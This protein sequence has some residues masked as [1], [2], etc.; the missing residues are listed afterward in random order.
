MDVPHS[1]PKEIVMALDIVSTDLSA[2]ALA[3]ECLFFGFTVVALTTFITVGTCA[4]FT[5]DV[6]QG[7]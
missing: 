7:E 5:K 1:L 4:F 2:V 6:M 3:L